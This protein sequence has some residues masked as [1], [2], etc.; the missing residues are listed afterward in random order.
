MPTQLLGVLFQ[1]LGV[2]TFVIKHFICLTLITLEQTTVLDSWDKHNLIDLCYIIRKY[3]TRFAK[4]TNNVNVPL[5][6]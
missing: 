6:I 1:F 5:K 4:P 2:S 3:C